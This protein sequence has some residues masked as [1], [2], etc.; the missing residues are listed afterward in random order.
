MVFVS[1][2][3]VLYNFVGGIEESGG[4]YKMRREFEN[5]S[6]IF[7][8]KAQIRNFQKNTNQVIPTSNKSAAIISAPLPP[9]IPSM[10][11]V[12]TSPPIIPAPLS[13]KLEVLGPNPRF[14]PSLPTKLE[15]RGP[16]PQFRSSLPSKLQVLGPNPRGQ[17]Y[18]SPLPPVAALAAAARK[19]RKNSNKTGGK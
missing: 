15:V 5:L 19:T 9:V 6:E 18:I 8:N 4:S 11:E 14:I 16:N 13:T 7:K 10:P 3:T 17:T 2:Q 1:D 12:N